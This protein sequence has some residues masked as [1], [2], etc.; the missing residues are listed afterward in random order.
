MDAR[1]GECSSARRSS[2]SDVGCLVEGMERMESGF[3]TLLSLRLL[4]CVLKLASQDELI[5]GFSTGGSASG[6]ASA[7]GTIPLIPSSDRMP[8]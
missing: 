8:S 7:D 6:K 1:H 5:F 4:V 3:M 2:V